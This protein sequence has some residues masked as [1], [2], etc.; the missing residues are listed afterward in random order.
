MQPSAVCVTFVVV[1]SRHR[2]ANPLTQ[3][4]FLAYPVVAHTHYPLFNKSFYRPN[5]HHG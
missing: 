1:A 2:K 4:L 3:R 5:W